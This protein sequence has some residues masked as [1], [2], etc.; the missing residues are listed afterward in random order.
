MSA[1]TVL[2]AGA[3]ADSGTGAAVSTAGCAV[4]KLS[5]AMTANLGKSPQVRVMLDTGPTSS[6]PWLEVY[7]EHFRSGAGGG[8]TWP[9][10][11]VASI[12]L[13]PSNYVR[14]RWVTNHTGPSTAEL[15]LAITGVGIPDA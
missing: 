5:A 8:N 15:D 12:T 9:A 3:K 13:M 10:S 4:L 2:A 7:A 14:A 1:V 11:S 6:G